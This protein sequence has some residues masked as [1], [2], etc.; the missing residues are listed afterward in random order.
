MLQVGNTFRPVPPSFFILQGWHPGL[1]RS[2]WIGFS[3]CQEES[4]TPQARCFTRN[5]EVL[6][7]GIVLGK[8]PSGGKEENG[9]VRQRLP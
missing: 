8:V 5:T 4:E 1:E 3:R 2:V 9:I 6:T 7:H